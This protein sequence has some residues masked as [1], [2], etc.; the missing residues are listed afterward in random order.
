LELGLK[1]VVW[2]QQLSSSWERRSGEC[3][4]RRE[5]TCP[6]PLASVADDFGRKGALGGESKK[7]GEGPARDCQKKGS[8]L[9]SISFG[10]VYAVT[11]HEGLIAIEGG[12]GASGEKSGR[13]YG[14]A[15]GKKRNRLEQG[16]KKGKPQ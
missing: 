9:E 1:K 14:T 6:W 16:G 12:G 4:K 5:K 8:F 11:G 13:D 7:R 2:K 3:P 10:S 15:S